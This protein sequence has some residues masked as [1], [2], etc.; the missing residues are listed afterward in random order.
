MDPNTVLLAGLVVA[1]LLALAVIFKDK[2]RATTLA[3]PPTPPTPPAEKTPHQQRVED[4]QARINRA[5]GRTE[6]AD[7]NLDAVGEEM[8]AKERELGARNLERQ[9]YGYAVSDEETRRGRTDDT[10]NDRH[11]QDE[12]GRRGRGDQAGGGRSERREPAADTHPPQARYHALS[13]GGTRIQQGRRQ[14]D[15][16]NVSVVL[17]SEPGPRGYEH[18]TQAFMMVAP[19]QGYDYRW[20]G[21]DQPMRTRGQNPNRWRIV[22]DR[23]HD[24]RLVAFR[25]APGPHPNPANPAAGGGL[26]TPPN[27]L[28]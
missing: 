16:P 25:T 28:V 18:D 20:E 2:L 14:V 24:L 6:L 7:L 4:F 9:M 12:V 1:G 15:L 17:D 8:R 21:Q 27:L 22:M 13:I 26:E 5:I 23:D 19:A 11:Q 3:N 10:R